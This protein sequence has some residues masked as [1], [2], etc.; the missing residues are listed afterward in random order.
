MTLQYQVRLT[1]L[2]HVPSGNVPIPAAGASWC[3][4]PLL[5]A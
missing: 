3:A 1:G 4:A 2:D 5:H